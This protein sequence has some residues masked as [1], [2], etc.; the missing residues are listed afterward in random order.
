MAPLTDKKTKLWIAFMNLGA[1]TGCHQMYDRSFSF[2]GYQFPL[3]ARCTGIVLGEFIS[4][5]AILCGVRIGFLYAITL[6]FPLAIDGGLQYIK[7]WKSNNLR[8]IITGL[9]AGFG[10]TYVYYY[11][12]VSLVRIVVKAIE[13]LR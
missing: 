12:V 7:L 8:R 1:K 11:V 2:K 13:I 6:I 3:C 9:F 5:V 10:L 4:I